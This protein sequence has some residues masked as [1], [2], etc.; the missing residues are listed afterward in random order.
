MDTSRKLPSM[1]TWPRWRASPPY[2]LV[3]L[4]ALGMVALPIL[5]WTVGS[6]ALPWAVAWNVVVLAVTSL[7]ALL[8]EWPAAFVIR[9]AMVVM[10][11]A[12]FV[13]YVGST[14]GLP[15]GVYHYT[16]ALQPQIGGVPLLIPLAWLMMLPA[17]WAVAWRLSPRSRW[18]FTVIAGLA[19]TAWDLFLDPQMAAWGFWIWDQPG[20][21]FGIPWRNFAGWFVSSALLTWAAHPRPLPARPLL[22]VYTITWFLQSVGL[23]WF[24]GMTGP[25]LSGAVG[26]GIFVLLAWQ[27]H[28]R[29]PFHPD[30]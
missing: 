10:L 21:Y 18:G 16:D 12:W 13:E 27:Q 19:F 30:N 23:A 2:L 25:A 28:L 5:L 11:G 17:A 9:S 14:T 8:H 24:W 1:Q 7:V 6:A 22:L 3:G 20:G 29:A 15:F 4:W 26:M